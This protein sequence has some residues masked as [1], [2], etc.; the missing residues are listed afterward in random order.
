[1]FTYLPIGLSKVYDIPL[2]ILLTKDQQLFDTVPTR[3]YHS[4]WV[5]IPAN[6]KPKKIS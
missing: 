5:L 3:H 2:K 1:M 6:G 4:K